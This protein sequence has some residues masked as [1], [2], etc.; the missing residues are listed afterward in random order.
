LDFHERKTDEVY[1]RSIWHG[2]AVPLF[3]AVYRPMHILRGAAVGL[4]FYQQLI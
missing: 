2:S 1:E 4:P 3:I